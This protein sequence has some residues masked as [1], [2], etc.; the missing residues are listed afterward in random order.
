MSHGRFHFGEE[1]KKV[2]FRVKSKEFN[3]EQSVLYSDKL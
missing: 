3:Q 2:D 1:S